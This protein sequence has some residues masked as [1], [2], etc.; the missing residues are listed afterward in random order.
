MVKKMP[1]HEYIEITGICTDLLGLE[2]HCTVGAYVLPDEV[3]IESYDL[4]NDNVSRDELVE[5][6][7]HVQVDNLEG[8][9]YEQA[10]NWRLARGSE[11]TTTG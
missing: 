8:M 5:K 11:E 7:G 2:W 9:L 6:F 10:D 4:E 3:S 1:K